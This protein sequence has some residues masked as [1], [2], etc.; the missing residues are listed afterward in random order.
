MSRPRALIAALCYDPR[1]TNPTT[2]ILLALVTF[3]MMTGAVSAQQ[4]TFYDS[5]GKVVG[6]PATDS[7][8]RIGATVKRSTR[9]GLARKI[10]SGQRRPYL[11][12]QPLNIS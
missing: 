11:R 8:G 6:R 1:M 9:H 12:S 3:A 5:F 4:R 10:T 2:K 7:S